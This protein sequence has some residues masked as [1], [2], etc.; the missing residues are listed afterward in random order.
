LERKDGEH[1]FISRMSIQ[2]NSYVWINQRGLR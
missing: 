2:I 1:L